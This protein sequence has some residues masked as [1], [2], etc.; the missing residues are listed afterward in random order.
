MIRLSAL[1]SRLEL[2]AYK[3]FVGD[4][5]PGYHGNETPGKGS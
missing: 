2:E 4:G 5:V 1:L 3:Y